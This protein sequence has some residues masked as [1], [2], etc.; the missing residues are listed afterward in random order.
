MKCCRPSQD[1]AVAEQWL[2]GAIGA[3][4]GRHADSHAFDARRK[5]QLERTIG[6]RR[7]DAAA[8]EDCVQA[9]TLEVERQ[10]RSMVQ[11]WRRFAC[12]TAASPSA[13]EWSRRPGDQFTG[14]GQIPP[15][16]AAAIEKLTHWAYSREA[17]S[18]GV[19]QEDAR[20]AA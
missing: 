5:D 6:L 2:D 15:V 19:R 11:G 7:A 9:A 3:C 16:T 8:R 13:P 14:E 10:R 1:G 4:L 12:A 18:R 20:I 17:T